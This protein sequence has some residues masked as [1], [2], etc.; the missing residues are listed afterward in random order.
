MPIFFM[1]AYFSSATASIGPYAMCSGKY[2][3]DKHQEQ[4]RVVPTGMIGKPD[5]RP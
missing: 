3:R 1:K 2:W 5:H 4:Q